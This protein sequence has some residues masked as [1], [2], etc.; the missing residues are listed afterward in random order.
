MAELR[1][2]KVII[3][4]GNPDAKYQQTRH[5]AGFKVIDAL[6]EQQG[7]QWVSSSDKQTASI[8]IKGHE[9][10]LIKPMTYMN[11]S[12]IVISFLKRKGFSPEQCLVIHDELEKL[13]GSIS[14]KMGGSARGHNGLKSLIEAWGTQE[15]P[16]IRFGIGRPENKEDVPTYVLQRFEPKENVDD[17]VWQTVSLIED[18]Y[19]PAN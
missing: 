3:G 2:P 15:F 13:P 18:L 12:G 1:N 8:S 6:A 14:L 9:V 17:H 16:R 7:G 11:N 19:K 5:N 4:L 10:L